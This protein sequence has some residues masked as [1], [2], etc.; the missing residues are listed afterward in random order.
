MGGIA[1]RSM[2]VR[3]ESHP[4]AGWLLGCLAG[5]HAYCKGQHFGSNKRA[6]WLCGPFETTDLGTVL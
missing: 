5:V 6:S 3:V 2:R 4:V 1:T